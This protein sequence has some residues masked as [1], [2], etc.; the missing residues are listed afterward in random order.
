MPTF[1]AALRARPGS[2]A[3]AIEFAILTGARSGEVRGA[4]R[5]E[6]DLV[7]KTWTV[8]KERMKGGRLHR[9]PLSA[10]A[11]ALLEQ[12]DVEHMQAAAPLFP[13]IKSAKALSDMSLTM[14]LRRLNDVPEG[15]PSPWLDGT[16]GEPITVHGFRSTFRVSAGE[17]TAYPREVIEQA[18]SHAVAG[19]Y[20]RTDL[21]EKR[22]ALMKD[23]GR[24]CNATSLGNAGVQRAL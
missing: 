5:R 2:S 14:V 11:L 1:L 13:G 23:W 16:T 9:V 22:R 20:A 21:L 3:R 12:L 4:T 18:L 24:C 6:L 7:S 8:P 15:Q 10:A 17:E 19:A